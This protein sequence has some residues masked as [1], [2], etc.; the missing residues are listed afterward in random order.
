MGPP[1]RIEQT[2]TFAEMTRLFWGTPEPTFR[3]TWTMMLI[4]DGSP[5]DMVAIDEMQ[6]Q[7]S[8]ATWQ[9]GSFWHA[10]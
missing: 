7:S 9:R 5:D 1:G 8:T 10:T 2:R 4:P 3:H 6:R